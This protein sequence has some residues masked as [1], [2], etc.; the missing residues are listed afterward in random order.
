MVQCLKHQHLLL[1]AFGFMDLVFS[2]PSLAAAAAP[3]THAAHWHFH[4]LDSL[5]PNDLGF[6]FC[7]GSSMVSGPH[8]SMGNILARRQKTG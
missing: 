1:P 2:V 6:G 5:H 3:A 4:A 8:I 7:L